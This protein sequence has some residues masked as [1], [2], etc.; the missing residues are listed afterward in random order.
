MQ[1]KTAQPKL[2]SAR[3][4]VSAA[5]MAAAIQPFQDAPQPDQP[6]LTKQKKKKIA[7]ALMLAQ[8]GSF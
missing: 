5:L 4:R 2:L 8:T 6:K 1:Q 3:P 7:A